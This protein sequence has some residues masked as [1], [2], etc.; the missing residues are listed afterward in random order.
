MMPVSGDHSAATA[1]EKVD[2][3]RFHADAVRF[4]PGLERH[5]LVRFRIVGGDDE[6]AATCEGNVVL[7]TEFVEAVAA[8][9]AQARL[10]RSGRIVNAGV[11]HAAVVRAGGA[12]D[13]GRAFEQAD[14]GAALGQ[15]QGGG[16]A[17]DTSADDCDIDFS[18]PCRSI[19]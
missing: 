13:L 8:F 1:L 15:E 5:Q 7:R 11:D 17:G 9:H 14:A 16:E 18:H 6:L 12:S 4:R 2:I 10:Q 19:I 3:G